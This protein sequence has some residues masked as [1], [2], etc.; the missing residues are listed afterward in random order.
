MNIMKKN[1]ILLDF[2]SLLDIVLIILFFFIL[3]SQF[4]MDQ[5]KALSQMKVDEAELKISE[6]NAQI[7][8]ANEL[9]TRLESE[10]EFLSNSNERYAS[11]IEAVIEFN[12]GDNLKMILKMKDI[13]WE[14]NILKSSQLLSKI[15]SKSDLASEITN[16]LANEG[17]NQNESLF[18]E[19]ILDG[20]EPGTASAYRKILSAINKVK[21]QYNYLYF[22]DTDISEVED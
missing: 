3:F 14:L 4:E 1:D 15:S 20:A 5:N 21:L 10:L 16:V 13:D 22:S 6:A 17:Y 7:E 18:I 19:F 8:L 9:T 11:N 12:R 2:T